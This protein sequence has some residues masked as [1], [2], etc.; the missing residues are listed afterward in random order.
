MEYSK[1]CAPPGRN[2]QSYFQIFLGQHIQLV[3][4][5]LV[6]V[7]DCQMVSH[8]RQDVPGIGGDLVLTPDHAV[9][10]VAQLIFQL[11][12][13]IFIVVSGHWHCFEKSELSP[14]TYEGHLPKFA[15]LFFC[16]H[17]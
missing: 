16:C 17:L 4:M 15:Y 5:S 12:L 9:I 2:V 13:Q 6:Y 1:T 8:G 11:I 3:Q 10:Q 7:V 14:R